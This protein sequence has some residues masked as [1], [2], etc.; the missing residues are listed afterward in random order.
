[1][2]GPRIM[3]GFFNLFFFLLG[4]GAYLV[5]IKLTPGPVAQASLLVILGTIWNARDGT[6]IATFKTFALPSVL[7][8]WP[9]I[10][11]NFVYLRNLR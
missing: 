8:L 5:V 9:Q 10:A 3:L 2:I 6:Y 4:E 11:F 1:M 7:S